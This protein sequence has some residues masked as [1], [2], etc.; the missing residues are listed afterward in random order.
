MS[1][2]CAET[3]DR[4][5]LTEIKDFIRNR[6]ASISDVESLEVA[7]K[8]FLIEAF[9]NPGKMISPA[10]DV[11]IFWHAHILHTRKYQKDCAEFFG[12]YIHHTPFGS[13]CGG[14]GD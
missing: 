3:L 9:S 12:K 14:D 5:D 7:Y 2:A 11:D 8:R 1:N 13:I 6:E 4:L 10:P